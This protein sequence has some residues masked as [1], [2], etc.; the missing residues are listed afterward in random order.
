MDTNATQPQDGLP[1]SDS[2]TPTDA[3][4]NGASAPAA[5]GEHGHGDS[6]TTLAVGAIGVVFGDI[7]TSPL[8]SFKETFVG[9]H[10]LKVDQTHVFGVLS[11]MFWTMVLIVTVKY[12]FIVL[13]ADNKGEGGS[14]ALLALVSRCLSDRRW[15]YVMALFGLTATALFFGDAMITPAVSVLSAVEGLTVVHPSFEHLVLP[16]SVEFFIKYEDLRADPA[17]T[18]ASVIS[19]IG[20]SVDKEKV[21]A[22]VE[23]NSL[24]R[25]R[26]MEVRERQT[27]VK[28]AFRIAGHA[29][30]SDPMTLFV[31]E[32]R[33]GQD[34]SHFGED[35][36]AAYVRRFSQLGALLG[37]T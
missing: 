30:S 29:N 8:Y 9:H 6:L 18:L 23:A 5:H 26:S 27:G 19:F 33:Q 10:L 22:C 12:L 24:L 13:R 4:A 14:L 2:T 20:Q 15:T 16:I 34:L 28:G 37:Y 25:M 31:G 11:I 35:I 1:A 36:E 32:G 17:S 21:A 3:P 7:G